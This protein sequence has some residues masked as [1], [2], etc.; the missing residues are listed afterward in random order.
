MIERLRNSRF[1]PPPARFGNDCVF[2]SDSRLPPVRAAGLLTPTGTAPPRAARAASCGT[3]TLP[4]SSR[5]E[6]KVNPLPQLLTNSSPLH[7]QASRITVQ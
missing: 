5:S 6:L 4:P 7:L 3:Q 2:P 1:P